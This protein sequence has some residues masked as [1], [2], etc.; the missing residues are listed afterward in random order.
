MCLTEL[1]KDLI[2]ISEWIKKMEFGGAKILITGSTGLIGSL[3]IRAIGVYNSVYQDQ[4]TVFA[5]ARNK[6]KVAKQ[7]EKYLQKDWLEFLYQD[8]CDSIAIDN[9]VDYIIH[10]ANSTNSKYFMTNPVEVIQ[11]IYLGTRQVLE[12]ARE[13]KIKGCVYLSSMEVFGQVYK[14]ERSKENELGYIDIK[15]VRSCYSEGKR[16][17]E[18]MCK[19][20]AEEYGVPVR[21]ARLAQTFGPGIQLEDNRVFAQFAR[22]IINQNDLV[23]HTEGNSLGNYCYTADAIKAILLLLKKG[24]YGEPYNVVNED[25]TISIRDMAKMVVD[26]FSNGNSKVIFDIPLEN[27][28]GYAADTKLKLSGKK[29]NSLGW[30]PQVGLEEAYRRMINDMLKG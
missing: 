3:L 23:L 15:N 14:E 28:Y 17:A 26:K 18:C 7:F 5:M 11:S 1:E 27:K 20:Y 8:I 19:A 6:E 22:S 4:I 12:I 13:K 30:I 29:I 10:T 2:D 21:I 16:M 25:T 9:D 24:G